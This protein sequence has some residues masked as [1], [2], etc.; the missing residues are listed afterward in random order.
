MFLKEQL[1]DLL[2]VPSSNKATVWA[3]D[4][5]KVKMRAEPSK[6]C[7]EYWNIPSGALVD[8]IEF[9]NE[10]THISSGSREGYM[11]TKYLTF[12]EMLFNNVDNENITVNRKRLE[13]I[14]DELGD[15]LGLRG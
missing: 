4:G 12:G 14:Y 9:G 15:I 1:S 5:G 7:G 11:M 3:P 10:W 8:V 6:D 13:D 2:G